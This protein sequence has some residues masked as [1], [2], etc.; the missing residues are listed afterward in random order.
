MQ[1][2][3]LRCFLIPFKPG[4]NLHGN[5]PPDRLIHDLARH[6]GLAFP[7]FGKNNGN[8][9]NIEPMFPCVEFHL[10][11]ECVSLES[12]LIKID[13]LKHMFAVADKS[14]SGILDFHPGDHA[15]VFGSKK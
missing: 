5:D 2:E 3:I 11:L 6:F 15:H 12:D 10:D 14:G 4:A 1:L 13:G 9:N 7:A 8:L